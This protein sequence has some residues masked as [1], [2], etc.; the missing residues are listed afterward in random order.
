LEKGILKQRDAWLLGA[1]ERVIVQ[2][3]ETLRAKRVRVRKSKGYKV[4][5]RTG[6]EVRKLINQKF[7]KPTAS[8]PSDASN[9]PDSGFKSV[10]KIEVLSKAE[11]MLVRD[12]STGR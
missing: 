7:T 11:H 4:R 12:G 9:G 1:I 10:R 6:R 5:K 8:A 2:D 3:L